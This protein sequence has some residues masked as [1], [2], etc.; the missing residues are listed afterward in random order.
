MEIIVP[1]FIAKMPLEVNLVSPALSTAPVIV[2]FVELFVSLKFLVPVVNWGFVTN[3]GFGRYKEPIKVA[4][5]SDTNLKLLTVASAPLVS[6]FSLVPTLTLPL[7]VPV[8]I[9]DKLAVSMFNIVEV[10]E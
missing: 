10:A 5:E 3:F 6:P 4:A 2:E 9:S 8:V 7:N 1:C